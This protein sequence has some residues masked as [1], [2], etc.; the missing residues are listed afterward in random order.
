MS[1]R[2]AREIGAEQK[3]A[4]PAKTPLTAGRTFSP[5][6]LDR[7]NRITIHLEIIAGRPR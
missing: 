6:E 1:I 4:L 7:L 5:R 3:K 2:Y